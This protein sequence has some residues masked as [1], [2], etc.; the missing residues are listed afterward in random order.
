MSEDLAGSPITSL[1]WV[2]Q[3]LCKLQRALAE[4]GVELSPKTIQR[5]LDA[6]DIRAK[7]VVRHLTPKPHPQ[8]NQQF[9][10]I[11]E[12]RRRFE[13]EGWPILS[14]DTK[15]RELIGLF[16][17]RGGTY[18]RDAL[19]V[20]MH[21]FPSDAKA[22][23]VPQGIYDVTENHGMVYVGL[24]GNTPDF[25]VE[26]MVRWWRRFGCHRYHG[27]RQVLILADG[28]GNSGYRPVRW[29]TGLQSR[30]VDAFGLTTTV[31][32]YPPG[33]SKWNPIEHRLFSQISLTWAGMPL[34]DLEV[35]LDAIRSTTT[36]TGLSVAAELLPGIFPTGLKA[37]KEEIH[38]LSIRRHS[39]CPSWNY[40]LT[41]RGR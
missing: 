39:M 28:G 33:A 24:S 2:R 40:M 10:H 29:K 12:E 6:H 9:E 34:T 41:P 1:R 14:I 5:V 7:G 15:K 36:Q 21:D 31:C 13:R 17:H 11:L 26:A 3:S 8:R 19:E 18:S 27:T 32:H 22:Y 16:G 35:M 23:T 38:A 20:Y 25:V 4:R 30:W 37:S